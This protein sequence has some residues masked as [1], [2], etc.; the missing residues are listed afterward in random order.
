MRINS[1]MHTGPVTPTSRTMPKCL[2]MLQRRAARYACHD[3]RDRTPGTVKSLLD[4]RE[5]NSLEQRSIHNRL[6]MLYRINNGLVDIDLSSYC[7]HADLR[8]R[9][10]RRLHQDHTSHPV[11]FNSFFTITIRDWSHL[12]VTATSAASLQS[13]RNH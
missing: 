10:A 8:T 5:W 2:K 7:H 13:F 4:S 9:K 12:P 11:L 3:F 1:F 6:K